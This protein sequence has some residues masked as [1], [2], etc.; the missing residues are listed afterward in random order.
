[1]TI[2]E[3]LSM[4]EKQIFDRKSILIK[5]VDLS[6]TIC[7]FANADGGTIAIGIS[8]KKRRIE[9]VDRHTEHLND[10]LRT[11]IDFCN[12]TVP[13]TTEMVECVNSDGEPDHVLLMH[14]EASPVLHANQADEVFLRVGDKSK[15]LDFN[16]SQDNGQKRGVRPRIDAKHAGWH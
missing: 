9:G 14:V 15:K 1:M 8:D 11:P 10:I 12:P 16:D 2:D 5:P 4:D 3:V 6:D 13:V 7:A